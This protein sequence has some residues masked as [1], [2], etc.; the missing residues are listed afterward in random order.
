MPKTRIAWRLPIALVAIAASLIGAAGAQASWNLAGGVGTITVDSGGDTV[1]IARSG[2]NLVIT[3]STTASAAVSS[4]QRLVV[5]LNGKSATVT[6]DGT[7][8]DL[9]IADE[10]RV[11]NPAP[12]STVNLK[13]R[14]VATGGSGQI[15]LNAPT[16]LTGDTTLDASFVGVNRAVDGA[17]ALTIEGGTIAQA[18]DLGATTPLSSLTVN[19]TTA[20]LA[21]SVTTSGVQTFSALTDLMLGDANVSLHASRVTHLGMVEC[22]DCTGVRTLTIDVLLAS[23]ASTVSDLGGSIANSPAGLQYRLVKAGAGTLGFGAGAYRNAFTGGTV[24]DGGVLNVANAH[25]LSSGVVTVSSGATLVSSAD[26]TLGSSLVVNGVLSMTAAQTITATSLSGAGAISCGIA[27]CGEVAVGVTDTSGE[28]AFSGA[29][30]GDGTGTLGNFN[31]T[32]SGNGTLVLGGVSHTHGSTSV[33]AGELRVTGSIG[34]GL[35]VGNVTVAAGARLTGTGSIG[36]TIAGDGSGISAAGTVDLDPGS[37]P[38]SMTTAAADLRGTFI[39]GVDSPS[40]HSSLAV[41]NGFL[42]IGVNA[43]LRVRAGTGLTNGTAVTI[44]SHVHPDSVVGTFANL[45]EGAI[46]TPTSGAGTFRISYVGG[47]GNDVTL[48]YIAPPVAERTTTPSAGTSTSS[49]SPVVRT[50]TPTI[51]AAG[52]MTTSVT[53]AG[54]GAIT[55]TAVITSGAR[56]KAAAYCA[57]KLTVKR[58]GTYKLTC[59]PSKAMRARLRGGA[60]KL[61]VTTAFAPKGG[62]ATSSVAVVN[63]PRKR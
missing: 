36:G 3:G 62:K 18:A 63:A 17:R 46:V 10:I 8:A 23:P 60:L 56:A 1:T 40:T 49:S 55:Q 29:F 35:S 61:R 32:K 14:I 48:T 53:V 11:K 15:A 43:V 52:T 57:A 25:A 12:T 13:G 19:S 37:A 38:E 58:A 44:I 22:S 7:A 31:L 20:Q 26:L 51:N 34:T 45:P 9:A 5:D 16:T 39:V 54:P 4:V 24:I 6:L 59:A 33:N 41:Q 21:G 47:D 42:W 27:S 30:G 2:A 28:A 50:T